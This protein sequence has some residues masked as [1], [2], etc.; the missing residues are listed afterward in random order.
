VVDLVVFGALDAS[1]VGSE[2]I[3]WSMEVYQRTLQ[4]MRSDGWTV[5]TDEPII[6][7][8]RPTGAL[9]K[10]HSYQLLDLG[11]ERVGV[12]QDRTEPRTAAPQRRA[13]EQYHLE[14]YAEQVGW[15]A[16]K[17]FLR[18][19]VGE[20]SLANCEFKARLRGDCL[21]GTYEPYVGEF[22]IDYGGEPIEFLSGINREVAQQSLTGV[23]KLALRDGWRPIKQGPYWYSYRYV[24][25]E[26]IMRR[27]LNLD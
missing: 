14:V 15:A 12:S 9:S 19:L 23:H 24:G 2:V 11:D 4:S 25:D 10:H 6:G 1:T 21:N 22:Q 7:G 27:S 16:G 17:S 5:N 8:G 18:N 26:T 13:A 3:A 20:T